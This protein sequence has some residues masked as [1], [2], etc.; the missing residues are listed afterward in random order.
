MI[1]NSKV[2]F[3]NLN[4]WRRA[5]PFDRLPPSFENYGGTGMASSAERGGAFGRGQSASAFACPQAGRLWRD[6]KRRAKPMGTGEGWLGDFPAADLVSLTNL[7]KGNLLFAAT[8]LDQGTSSLKLAAGR[9]VQGAGHIAG[10]FLMFIPVI[11]VR[12]GDG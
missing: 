1:V 5:H 3:F 10:Q 7:V 9:R 4:A 2:S 6:K 12:G 8:I 11:R